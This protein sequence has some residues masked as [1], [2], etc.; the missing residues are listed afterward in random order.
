MDLFHYSQISHKGPV[1]PSKYFSEGDEVTVVALDYNK[2]KRHLSLSIKEA[3]PDPWS[4][5]DD[6]LGV[7]DTVSAVLATLSLME[8]L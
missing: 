2:D 4:N 7:G 3:N 6:I 8:L 1:N 5:I